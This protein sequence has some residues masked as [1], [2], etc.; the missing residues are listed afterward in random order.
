MTKLTDGPI[1]VTRELLDSWPL[2]SGGGSKY[3][4]GQ[5]VVVGGAMRSPGAAMLAGRAA[6]RVG[7]GRLTLA[8]GQSVAAHVGTAL[9]ESGVAP[10]AE[11]SDGHVRG[12]GILAARSDLGS[13]DVVLVGPGLDDADET[14]TMLGHLPLLLNDTAIVVLDAFALGAIAKDRDLA[15]PFR[16]RLVVTPN[17]SEAALLLGRDPNDGGD[18]DVDD[19]RTIASSFDAV[20]S[21]SSVVAAPGQTPW[22]I[23]AGNAGLG[24]SGSGDTLAGAITGIAGRGATIS[25]AVV[26]ATWVHSAAGDSLS[27]R[28]GPLGYLA[29][30]IADE[31]PRILA[32][33]NPGTAASSGG[34]R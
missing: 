22:T 24:T 21:Y 15:V 23:A 27:Q 13:A 28:V 20:V 3:D 29:S 17:S 6:L 11:T 26:W 5:V 1:D 4:R 34:A 16:G 12:A 14:M 7:C 32:S 33:A 31:F 8:V 25:Q 19:A 2:P 10:L 30:E 18:D 9:P